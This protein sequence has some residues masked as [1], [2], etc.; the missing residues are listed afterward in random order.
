MGTSCFLFYTAATTE[1][2]IHIKH[3]AGDKLFNDYPRDQL[4]WYFLISIY[5]ETS[6]FS[7]LTAR[8]SNNLVSAARQQITNEWWENNMIVKESQI[9]DEI[10]LEL[11]K[12]KDDYSESCNKSFKK[13]ANR[14]KEDSEKVISVVNVENLHK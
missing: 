6:I 3:K 11:W 7:Y 2:R 12:I 5:L 1:T 13:L 10:L 9:K 4:S 14:L 8:I